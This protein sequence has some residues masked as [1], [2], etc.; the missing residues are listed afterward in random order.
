MWKHQKDFKKAL[1]KRLYVSLKERFISPVSVTVPAEGRSVPL[2]TCLLSQQSKGRKRSIKANAFD[3]FVRPSPAHPGLHIDRRRPALRHCEEACRCFRN[4][5]YNDLPYHKML[6]LQVFSVPWVSRSKKP[7]ASGACLSCSRACIHQYP[8]HIRTLRHVTLT[9]KLLQVQGGDMM[10]AWDAAAPRIPHWRT[11]KHNPAGSWRWW[12]SWKPQVNP[13]Y[14]I[15]WRL[16]ARS[17]NK[18]QKKTL[19]MCVIFA[20]NGSTDRMTPQPDAGVRGTKHSYRPCGY[21][22]RLLG[23]MF[24]ACCFHVL[25]WPRIRQWAQR[26]AVICTSVPKELRSLLRWDG[27]PD[28]ATGLTTEEDFDWWCEKIL[29]LNIKF[30]II[31][32]SCSFASCETLNNAFRGQPGTRCIL[33]NG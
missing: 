31:I 5:D 23:H 9:C 22:L 20:N 11:K 19:C 4:Y 33:H 30:S 15:K 18:M 25:F 24:F 21:I 26:W 12:R 28:A 6:F 3:C 29:D 10:L 1:I 7:S 16:A 32:E 13:F 17:E 2:S 14:P 8:T 27:T